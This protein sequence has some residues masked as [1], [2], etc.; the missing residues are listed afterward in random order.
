MQEAHCCLWYWLDSLEIASWNLEHI[1]KIF[2][3][4]QQYNDPKAPSNSR[5]FKNIGPYFKISGSSQSIG[6]SEVARMNLNPIYIEANE[7]MSPY[8]GGCTNYI[9]PPVLQ[10]ETRL[11]SCTEA[12]GR[13]QIWQT[14]LLIHHLPWALHSSLC[15]TGHIWP[16]SGERFQAQHRVSQYEH[17]T[18]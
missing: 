4:L 18:I 3:C 8:S 14:L 16:S 17:L 10:S 6:L 1:F 9:K 12:S 7:Y 5:S 13:I 11:P 2:M 15:W